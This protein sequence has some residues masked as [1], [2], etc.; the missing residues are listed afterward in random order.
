M[1]AR[2][3]YA[4]PAGRLTIAALAAGVLIISTAGGGYLQWTDDQAVWRS[5]HWQEF[6]ISRGFEALLGVWLF[7]VGASIASFL[8]VV[9]WRV[10]RRMPINGHSF[11]P[12]CR[13]PI[14]A[15][16]NLPII[17]WLRLRGRCAACSLPIDRR[18]P[19]F[20]AV[21][22]FLFLA[23]YV[24]E[25][26]SHGANWPTASTS[27]LSYGVPTNL[28]FLPTSITWIVGVHLLLLSTLLAALMTRVSAAYLPAKAYVCAIAGLV[29][30]QLAV[31]QT[32]FV[33]AW[34][35]TRTAIP[36]RMDLA[37][38]LL[39]AAAAGV[40]AALVTLRRPSAEE[41]LSLADAAETSSAALRLKGRAWSWTAAIVAVAVVFQIPATLWI[42]SFAI[43]AAA[44]VASLG[45]SKSRYRA[46]ADEFCWLLPAAVVALFGWRSLT[47]VSLGN[48]VY[49][50]ILSVALAAVFM[51][52]VRSLGRSDA[53]GLAVP[54]AHT[55]TPNSL[56]TAAVSSIAAAPQ[57]VTR[58]TAL[59]TGEPPTRADTPPSN[60]S[61]ISELSE[62]AHGIHG[63]GASTETSNG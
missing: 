19:I 55:A 46:A 14:A 25:F 21:G 23:V 39:A 37:I 56:P 10:P 31:P 28:R 3:R 15:S 24:V 7:T 30:I 22:G 53:G 5:V 35:R 27:G 59:P 16:D 51:R 1:I 6:I 11:C 57:N 41:R 13:T 26:L 58:T 62:T 50:A 36:D 49:T 43:V 2:Q 48:L 33:D 61:D 12:R 60:A 32:V 63:R 4:T 44:L 45:G 17:G 18:Y 8:N 34:G 42:V 54:T 20:E 52:I 9:A 47:A 29:A 38:Q 40:F